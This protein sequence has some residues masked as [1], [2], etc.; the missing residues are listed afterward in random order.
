[1]HR[2]SFTFGSVIDKRNML[3]TKSEILRSVARFDEAA[4]C[5]KKFLKLNP[6]DFYVIG[7]LRT[8]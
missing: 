3:I 8:Y 7:L 6:N 4:E 1:M 5:L 2:K